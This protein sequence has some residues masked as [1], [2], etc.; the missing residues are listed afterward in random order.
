[1]SFTLVVFH[2][3]PDDE[4]LLTGGTMARAADEGHRVVLVT[5]TAGEAGLADEAD[6]LASARTRELSRAA[7]LLGCERVELL[8]YPDS[9]LGPAPRRPQPSFA[10]IDPGE[11]AERLAQ[12]LVEERADALTVY[13]EHGGYGHRDHVQVHRVGVLAAGIAQTSVVLEA[14]VD[15]RALSRAA[16]ILAR[17]PKTAPLIPADHFA[18][19]YTS[20][21]E[22]T[23]RVDVRQWL[24]RK[25]AAL[26]A[27]ASQASGGDAIRT[28]RLLTSLPAPIRRLAL[29]REWYRERGRAPG[30]RPLDDVF[31]SLR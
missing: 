6:D 2:A 7:E 29:G 12:I 1:V 25:A 5:A 14:T 28:I 10:E 31:A 11:P 13:D 26:A 15:R 4:A 18:S 20:H 27:H 8:G 9:G 21:A 19:A 16:A 30:G 3:H 22:L 23:H 17:V 24:D